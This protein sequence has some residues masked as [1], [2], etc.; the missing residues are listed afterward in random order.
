[1]CHSVSLVEKGKKKKKEKKI[2]VRVVILIKAARKFGYWTAPGSSPPPELESVQPP[3]I[4]SEEF[5]GTEPCLE[6]V[7]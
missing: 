3:L 1:M 2:H 4:D 5:S 7:Q 6:G